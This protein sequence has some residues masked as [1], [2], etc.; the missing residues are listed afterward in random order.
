MEGEKNLK[1]KEL[2]EYFKTKEAVQ[3]YLLYSRE[4]IESGCGITLTNIEAT[5]L[6][7]ITEKVL[8]EIVDVE[9]SGRPLGEDSDSVMDPKD[10]IQ[11]RFLHEFYDIGPK[12]VESLYNN[13]DE[14]F[15]KE[16][17]RRRQE[18]LHHDKEIDEEEE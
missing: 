4:F 1:G 14:T 10:E 2:I 5:G 9:T 17:F 11:A 3:E 18:T 8:Q 12:E 13:N 16:F 7:M 15:F 6:R